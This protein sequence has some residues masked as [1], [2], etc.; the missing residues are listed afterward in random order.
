MR[1]EACTASASGRRVTRWFSRIAAPGVS[2]PAPARRSCQDQ[3]DGDRMRS[4]CRQAGLRHPA[5]G[6]S[7]E[8]ASP[9]TFRAEALIV[10]EVLD[11]KSI[12]NTLELTSGRMAK[13]ARR[14][15]AAR[16]HPA[17][18]G[19]SATPR[20]ATRTS[21]RCSTSCVLGVSTPSIRK[22]ASRRLRCWASRSTF[23]I[24]RAHRRPAAGHKSS[25]QRPLIRWCRWC[26]PAPAWSRQDRRRL[27]GHHPHAPPRLTVDAF[28][29]RRLTAPRHPRHGGRRCTPLRDLTDLGVVTTT[30]TNG[31]R[32]PQH[33]QRARRRQT[34]RTVFE[35]GTGILAPT[36]SMRSSSVLTS[37]RAQRS[38]PVGERS[39]AA[40]A[41]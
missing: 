7:H 8:C 28:K 33:A 25:T 32:S 41:A 16:S 38:H 20:L 13:L 10:V 21:S 19:Y 1:L 11:N 26:A 27:R 6:L 9:R 5:C 40:W 36:A 34:R 35:L 23:P 17:L 4:W 29:D 37:A 14:R 2:I 30:R 15:V 39:V 22:K 24:W 18:F 31:P 12:Y 3:Y